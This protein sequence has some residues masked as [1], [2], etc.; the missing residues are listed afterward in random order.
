MLLLLLK[1]LLHLLLLHLL[2][3]HLMLLLLL[4]GYL[5]LKHNHILID[6]E[7]PKTIKYQ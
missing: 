3:L 2:L 7:S 4:T 1:L 5:R 6:S